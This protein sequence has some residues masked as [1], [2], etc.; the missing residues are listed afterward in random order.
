MYYKLLAILDL[1]LASSSNH[2]RLFIYLLNLYH[3]NLSLFFYCCKNPK[4]SLT[5]HH[6]QTCD[7]EG[8]AFNSQDNFASFLKTFFLIWRKGRF[9]SLSWK[10]LHL[11]MMGALQ[12]NHFWNQTE[13]VCQYYWEIRMKSLESVSLHGFLK[14]RSNHSVSLCKKLNKNVILYL[15]SGNNSAFHIW[16]DFNLSNH[17]RRVKEVNRKSVMEHSL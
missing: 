4:L 14:N 5:F 13:R 8:N 17:F 9:L 1:I 15:W 16:S 7:L 3:I 10:L 12:G 2:D 11:S 6:P